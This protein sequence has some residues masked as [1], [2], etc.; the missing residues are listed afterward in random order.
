M[1][2]LDNKSNDELV[3]VLLREAAK[4]GNEL[5]CCKADV[6]KAQSRLGFILM[7]LNV[8]T[9]RSTDNPTTD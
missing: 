4:A 1:E 3:K 7:I 5:R 2:I 9:D 8:I 6:E